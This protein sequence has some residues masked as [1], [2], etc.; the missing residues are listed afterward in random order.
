MADAIRQSG[1]SSFGGPSIALR[2]KTNKDALLGAPVEAAP[3]RKVGTYV[4]Q[5]EQKLGESSPMRHHNGKVNSNYNYPQ[6]AFAN[7]GEGISVKSIKSTP[8]Q[9]LRDSR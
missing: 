4:H 3:I 7:I 2:M 9:E 6:P 8:A 1:I 5:S